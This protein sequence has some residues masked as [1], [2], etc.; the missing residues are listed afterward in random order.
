MSKFVAAAPNDE[1]IEKDD[2]WLKA[3]Q[4]IEAKQVEKQIRDK[5]GG[6]GKSLYDTLQANKGMLLIPHL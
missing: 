5:D 3:Q 2:V 1:H 4:A 6:A